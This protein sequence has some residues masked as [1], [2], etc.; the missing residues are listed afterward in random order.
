VIESLYSDAQRRIKEQSIDHSQDKENM[1]DGSLIV[2]SQKKST[3]L[4]VEKIE[5]ELQLGIIQLD[6]IDGDEQLTLGQLQQFLDM[7]GYLNSKSSTAQ[8]ENS[9]LCRQVWDLLGCKDRMSRHKLRLVLYA[10]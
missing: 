10:I 5:K 3:R 1:L 4:L 6:I 8:D 9:E 2:A 7:M